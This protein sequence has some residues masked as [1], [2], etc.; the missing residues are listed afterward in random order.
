M[1]SKTQPS[2]KIK[3]RTLEVFEKSKMNRN[4]V[5]TNVVV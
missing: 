1:K 5:I 4:K 3:A 2:R